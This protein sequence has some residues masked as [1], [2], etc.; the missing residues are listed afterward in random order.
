M[1]DVVVTGDEGKKTIDLKKLVRKAELEKLISTEE[2]NFEGVWNIEQNNGS[3]YIYV[4]PR[5][6]TYRLP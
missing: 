5:L 4:G 1:T 6:I 3:M 2:L